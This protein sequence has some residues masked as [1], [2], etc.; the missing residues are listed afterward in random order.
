FLRRP[1]LLSEPGRGGPDRHGRKPRDD[2][3]WP[4]RRSASRT[5]AA[6]FLP[7][8][9]RSSDI[10]PLPPRRIHIH[11]DDLISVAGLVWPEHEAQCPTFERLDPAAFRLWPISRRRP[12]IPEVP[13][14]FQAPIDRFQL[15]ARAE[16]V[17]IGSEHL[18]YR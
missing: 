2:N 17:A 12:G 6:A 5:A 16:P 1:A 3:T 11:R 18:S 10:T 7:S 8:R 14:R 9:P 4:P 15:P 13:C